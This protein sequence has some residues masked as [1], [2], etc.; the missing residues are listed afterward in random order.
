MDRR[1]EPHDDDEMDQK[2]LAD[3]V[4]YRQSFLKLILPRINRMKW[5]EG[6]AMTICVGRMNTQEDEIVWVQQH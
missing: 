2:D 5:W 6:D 3:V 4:E 1:F